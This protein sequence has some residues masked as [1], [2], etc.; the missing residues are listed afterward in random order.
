MLYLPLHRKSGAHD[1]VFS[2]AGG[3]C[4]AVF[5]RI[6]QI[7]EN[8]ALVQE[9]DDALYE[10]MAIM[11][12]GKGKDRESFVEEN[13]E[14][15]TAWLDLRFTNSGYRAFLQENYPKA[16]R[17]YQKQKKKTGY[18]A[19]LLAF[20]E[21]RGPG[22]KYTAILPEQNSLRDGYKAEF[23]SMELPALLLSWFCLTPGFLLLYGLAYYGALYAIN[24]GMLYSTGLP[25][26]NAAAVFLPA[27]LTSICVSYY[28]R[29]K[30]YRLLYRKKRE[31]ILAYDRILNAK[32]DDR[33]IQGL[34][35]VV[36]ICCIL[37]TVLSATN[38]ITFYDDHMI[39]RDSFFSLR[40][41]ELSYDAITSL[42]RISGRTNGFGAW[43]DNPS[44]VL[45][46]QTGR[47]I[48]LYEY[49]DLP[50]T[51]EKVLPILQERGLTVKCIEVKHP[52][53]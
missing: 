15:Y 21:S 53:I 35:R 10:D 25:G 27:F 4:G 48:D 22:D 5:A 6:A 3:S 42:W 17:W 2:G 47:Q 30:F 1:P 12:A 50:E 26:Y 18:E 38:N 31:K 49:L 40:G 11:L 32:G 46:T 45:V 39:V 16:V 37:F 28:T 41:E 29:Q 36:V 7:A 43:L 19:R 24:F 23:G 14:F 33:F 52:G 34:T 44:Y 20:L 51:E 13:I 8:P 9:A